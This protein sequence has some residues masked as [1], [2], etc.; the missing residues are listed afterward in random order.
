MKQTGFR[1]IGFAWGV[2]SGP[3]RPVI[4]LPI[5][6]FEGNDPYPV[7]AN[8]ETNWMSGCHNLG[9]ALGV[10][11]GPK[12]SNFE[13]LKGFQP[14]S[15]WRQPCAFGG[16]RGPQPWPVHLE[17]WGAP[18]P[19]PFGDR[20]VHLQ[21]LGSPNPCPFGGMGGPPTL[22]HLR[23][24]GPQSIWRPPLSIWRVGGSGLPR[25]EY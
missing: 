14:L 21:G 18:N 24:G 3:K 11:S 12:A 25:A 10:C 19:C 15:I 17:G 6:G 4:D 2:L 16:L 13:G 9:F 1:K 8:T 22:V 7:T 5:L 23:V 20:P